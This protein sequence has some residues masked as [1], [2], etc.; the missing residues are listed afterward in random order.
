[1]N[2][3]PFGTLKD[4]NNIIK[5]R[6]INL[7]RQN[8]IELPIRQTTEEVIDDWKDSIIKYIK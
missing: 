1:M 3:Y 2:I 6:I 4:N 5:P 8:W 7:I